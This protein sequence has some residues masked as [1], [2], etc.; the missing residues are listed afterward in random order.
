MVPSGEFIY[1]QFLSIRT[2]IKHT[3]YK[4]NYL[5]MNEIKNNYVHRIYV[6]Y[7]FF[8]FISIPFSITTSIFPAGNG[9]GEKTRLGW[10]ANKLQQLPETHS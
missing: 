6:I 8:R 3:H 2:E 10:E 5:R 4:R 9:N 1:T 7:S